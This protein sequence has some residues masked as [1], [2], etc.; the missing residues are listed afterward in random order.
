MIAALSG[1]ALLALVPVVYRR[2]AK[3]T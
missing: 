2:F 1:L 3:A